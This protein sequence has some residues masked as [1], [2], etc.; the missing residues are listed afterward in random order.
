MNKCFI[1]CWTGSL[2][3]TRKQLKILKKTKVI[4]TTASTLQVTVNIGNSELSLLHAFSR[5][6]LPATYISTDVREDKCEAVLRA[7]QG[8][9]GNKA[10]P[11]VYES[12]QFH[13]GSH[14]R[15]PLSED[16]RGMTGLTKSPD[17]LM[18]LPS[19]SRT[20]QLG[21]NQII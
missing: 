3:L 9:D 6:A 11:V 13:T 7:L 10:I 2:I 5:Y 15:S 16:Q 19:S 1:K 17:R 20:R 14:N 8:H 21:P 18:G 4:L 12:G